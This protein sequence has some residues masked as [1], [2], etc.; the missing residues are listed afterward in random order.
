MEESI[1]G[2]VKSKL[3]GMANDDSWFD[4]DLIDFVNATFAVMTQL[5]VGPTDGF[6]IITGNETWDEYE[7]NIT[8]QSLARSYMYAKVRLQFDPP[9]SGSV[10]EALKQ[11][12][13]EFEWRLN[14]QVDPG[15]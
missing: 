7:P 9:Q 4:D 5:G 6:V 10:L 11:I 3:G 12:I 15:E 2:S 1:L 13:S 14:V 8:T